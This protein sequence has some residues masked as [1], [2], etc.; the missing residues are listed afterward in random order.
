M[1]SYYHRISNRPMCNDTIPGR[2]YQFAKANPN[3]EAIVYYDTKFQRTSITRKQLYDGTEQFAKALV[4]QGIKKG[5]RIALCVSNCV[6]WMVYDSG[7]MMAGGCSV[8]L[9]AGQAD[10]LPMLEDCVAIIFDSDP[11]FHSKLLKVADVFENGNVV[12]EVFPNLRLAINVSKTKSSIKGLCY[13]KLIEKVQ[14]DIS[15]I[16]P[17]MEAEDITII[18]QTSGTTGK[19]KRVTHS[20]FDIINASEVYCKELGLTENDG[21]FNERYFGF[22]GS[23]PLS[24][25]ATGLKYVS[26]DICS[27]NAPKDFTKLNEILKNEGCKKIALMPSD[28]HFCPE[29]ENMMDFVMIAGD[30]TSLDNIKRGLSWST[31]IDHF[32]ATAET[33]IIGHKSFTKDNVDSY[34][35]GIIGRPFPDMEVKLV[36]DNN[37]IVDIGEEGY[38]CVRAVWC[39]K[40]NADGESILDKG[41]F[42]TTDICKMTENREIIL[43]GKDV[44]FIT[45]SARRVSIRFVEQRMLRY[46][47][48]DD[49]VV[50]PVPDEVHG[51]NICAC[52]IMK[53]GT[54][55]HEASMFQFCNEN[56]PQPN[57]FDNISSTPDYFLEFDKFPKLGNGKVDRCSMK[58]L[59]IDRLIQ[60]QGLNRPCLKSQCKIA[61]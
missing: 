17:R 4:K 53:H 60:K 45:K 48:V 6:E 19:P 47:D 3:K 51:S 30:M 24:F 40:V 23:Y 50:V 8:R 42:K 10:F 5:D 25:I 39:S 27:L 29:K 11:T 61:Q 18:S 2:L 31:L 52:L 34:V 14:N 1:A 41:W 57:N 15:I 55:M 36:D 44:D 59:A 38:L 20:S 21:F 43:Y 16:L 9:W 7:I 35:P 56:L 32:M 46:P 58:N 12:S 49:V 26:A 33:L 13:D 54:K 28:L 37:T 22:G